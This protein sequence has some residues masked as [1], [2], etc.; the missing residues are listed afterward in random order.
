M[1]MIHKV[2]TTR[3]HTASFCVWLHKKKRRKDE[4][5]TEPNQEHSDQQASPFPPVIFRVINFVPH[6]SLT[7]SLHAAVLEKLTGLQLVKKF[8]ALYGTRKFITVFTSTRHLS[9]SWARS[10]QSIPSHPTSWKYILK[11]SSHLCLGLQSGLFPSG[12]PT[13]TLYTPL[14]YP[15]R[16]ICPAHTIL[17]D[18]INGE[19]RSLSSLLCSF[20]HSPFT[21][22]PLGRNI[23]LN[24]IFSNTLTLH[25]SLDVSDQVA[26]SYNTTGNN[27]YIKHDF[28]QPCTA[29]LALIKHSANLFEFTQVKRAN[30]V[31]LFRD[32]H[33]TI[34]SQ[35][36]E[37]ATAPVG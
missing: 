4:R 24:T 15:M 12:F 8:P 10:S 20:L 28:L 31:T 3:I 23:L 32:P 36:A 9:L 21:S 19:F 1:C 25:S 18:F 2:H 22:S 16:A 14:I 6:Y 29:C 35:D 13:K 17:L 11:Q 27:V 26:H 5:T 34:S 7:H 37:Y 33:F 30:D